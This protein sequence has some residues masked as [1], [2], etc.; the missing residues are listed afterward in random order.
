MA[1]ISP[2]SIPRRRPGDISRRHLRAVGRP[3]KFWGNRKSFRQ[4]SLQKQKSQRA[5]MTKA[6]QKR[7]ERAHTRQYMCPLGGVPRSSH[8]GQSK[9]RTS[10]LKLKQIA[11]GGHHP[12]ASLPFRLRAKAHGP[13]NWVLSKIGAIPPP[14]R[15]EQRFDAS[16]E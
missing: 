9:R 3:G 4:K 7:K 10:K 2:D 13:Q 1:V 15:L 12:G 16:R 14:F 5:D 11:D 6:E 8:K